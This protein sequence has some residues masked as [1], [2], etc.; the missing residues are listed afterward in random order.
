[1]L[2]L[3]LFSRSSSSSE[4]D[5]FVKNMVSALIL[6]S[7]SNAVGVCISLENMDL[8]LGLMVS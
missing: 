1:M 3:S 6:T 8:I 2:S 4:V 5:Y 7:C